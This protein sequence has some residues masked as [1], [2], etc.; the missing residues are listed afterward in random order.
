MTPKQARE[1]RQI[2]MIETHNISKSLARMRNASG[3]DNC[4]WKRGLYHAIGMWD[5]CSATELKAI[6]EA[7]NLP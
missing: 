3:Y 4:R 7:M 1:T 2:E 6:R 5:G